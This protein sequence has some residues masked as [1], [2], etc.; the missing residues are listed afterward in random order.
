M[1]RHKLKKRQI[2]AFC[3]ML[4]FNLFDWQFEAVWQFYKNELNEWHLIAPR[5]N[6]KS[7]VLLVII[8][9]EMFLNGIK[10]TFTTHDTDNCDDMFQKLKNEIENNEDL[11]GE[12]IRITKTKGMQVIE[13]ANGSTI[14]FK[15]RTKSSGLGGSND[16][17]I[18]DELQ[19]ITEQQMSSI[20]PTLSA[21]KNPVTLYAGTHPRNFDDDTYYRK[22]RDI[23]FG[24]IKWLEYGIGSD[25]D[26]EQ[27]KKD[28]LFLDKKILKQT[29]PSYLIRLKHE[30][31]VQEYG[32][33]DLLDFAIQRLGMFH[34]QTQKALFTGNII[35]KVLIDTEEA[36]KFKGKF[37]LG[38]KFDMEY[39]AAVIATRNEHGAYLQVLDKRLNKDGFEWLATFILENKEIQGVMV[40]G[41]F[42]DSFHQQVSKKFNKNYRKIGG[43]EYI[44]AQKMLEQE[45]VMSKVKIANQSS[46][47]EELQNVTLINK[48]DYTK[49]AS[50]HDDRDVVVAEAMAIAH[51]YAKERL[52]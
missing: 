44:A 37:V 49:F 29:N 40:D 36:Q 11:Y 5:Q 9:I 31:I 47:S 46:I 2:Q 33:M 27:L 42:K 13:L 21:S 1:K 10:I 43:L 23:Y 25:Y 18:F 26:I 20:Y 45:I 35:N 19:L 15:A 22:Q 52:K 38:I 7:Q 16:M 28:N 48:K 8:L 6:G 51:H 30:S 17:V 4:T 3:D 50:I 34:T 14:K 24:T 39:H 41:L 12:L 32:K